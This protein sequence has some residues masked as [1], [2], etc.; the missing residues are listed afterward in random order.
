MHSK[1]ILMRPDEAMPI[2]RAASHAGKH[3]CTI[4]RWVE[5]YGIGRQSGKHAT[6]EVTRIGLD[7]VLQGDFEALELLR[8]GERN[9]PDVVRYF[10]FAGLPAS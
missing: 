8:A 9:H 5:Q 1:P 10:D 7:M 4:R 6:V 2:K 3:I